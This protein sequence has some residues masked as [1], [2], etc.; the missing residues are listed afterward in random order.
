MTVTFPIVALGDGEV[1]D[2]QWFADITEAVNDH[3]TRVETLESQV[4]T[5]SV[6][7]VDATAR[8]TTS[9]SFT[10]TISGSTPEMGVAFVAPTSGKVMI[11]W[12]AGMANGS[13]PNIAQI[14]PQVRAG[15]TINSGTIVLAADAARSTLTITSS[16]HAGVYI[17]TGLT[18][19]ASYNAV[20]TH[21]SFSAGTS[22]FDG[23]ELTV[24]P[25]IA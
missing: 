12:T 7:V 9:T 23:R 8:T 10:A 18:P 21:R 6:T 22:S 25:I 3:E 4:N 15:S 13:S 14:S 2:P 19:G 24:V 11:I 16:R 17:L 5:S 1:A 20:M